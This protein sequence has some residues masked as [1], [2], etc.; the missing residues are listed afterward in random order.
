M[1]ALDFIDSVVPRGGTYC[2]AGIKD[3]IIDQRFATTLEGVQSNIDVL[4]KKGNNVYFA[5][6]SFKDD[7]SRKQKNV[8]EMKSFF[9]DVDIGD[10]EKVAKKVAYAEK[11]EA[12]AAVRGFIDMAGLPHP[13]IVDSGGGWHVYWVLDDAI[14]PEKWQPIADMFKQLCMQSG[15]NIDPAVPADSARILRVVGTNNTKRKASVKFLV[16]VPI[17]EPIA[18]TQFTSPLR[19]ACAKYGIVESMKKPKLNYLMDAATFNASGNKEAKFSTIAIRSL[20]GDGCAQIAD[21]LANPKGIHYDLWCAGLSIANKCIDGATA[22]HKLSRGH[23]GYTAEAT[24]LKAAEFNNGPRTCDWFN[25]NFP[26]NC[27]NCKFKGQFATPIKLGEYVPESTETEVV[28]PAQVM[29]DEVVGEI[30]ADPIV[31]KFPPLPFP[32]FRGTGGGIY[33]KGKAVDGEVVEDTLIYENDLFVMKRIRDT[34]DGEILLFN[35]ILPLDGLQEFAIPLKHISSFDRLRDGLA[36][37]G[38]SATKKRMDEI[39]TYIITANRELQ[40]H[41]RLEQSRPQFGWH[42]SNTVFV[43][44]NREISATGERYSPPSTG[45]AAL[46][47]Y[48]NPKGDYEKWKTLVKTLGRPGW[49]RHQLG[50]LVAFGAPLM[51]F[52]GEHGLLI[53]LVNKDSGTGKTLVQHFINSV[54]GDTSRLMMRKQDTLASRMHGIGVR[55]HLPTCMDEVTNLTMAEVSDLA[56]G[57]SEGRGKERMESGANK[58]RVNNTWWDT[59][60]VTSSNAS[61]ADKLTTNKAT[62][63]GELMR[64]FEID[65]IKP[66]ELDADF[67]QSLVAIMQN[68]YGHA[69]DLYIKTVMSDI[70]GMEALLSKVKRSMNKRLGTQSKERMWVAAFSAIITGGYIAKS[71]GIIDWDIDYLFKVLLEL[72]FGKRQEATEELLDFGSVL[73]EFLSENKGAILQINGAKDLRSGL[74]QAPIFNPNVRIVGRFEPDSKKLYLVRSVFKEHCVKRQIPFN[75]SMT[76]SMDGIKFKGSEKLRVM[77]GTGIDAPPVWLL[78]FEGDFG[79]DDVESAS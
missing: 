51:K 64:I 11:S 79:M 30:I 34:E 75:A 31:I 55:C 19:E 53:N 8:Q 45:T 35:L 17:P 66:E 52:T 32:Y 18:L 59:I 68:N 7:S 46:A 14:T 10:P 4:V 67:A 78:V 43:L 61:M 23:D 29:F 24:E 2:I 56:Y 36:H 70:A 72:A 69:G 38:V 60:G 22:I 39:M 6:S 77:R 48:L 12:L 40:K 28:I 33:R 44:G 1:K 5:L 62:A 3:D 13:A 27:T 54:Y 74:P 16:G 42:D 47:Q 57:F 25:T 15:L 49:E 41:M 65:I 50:A 63:D 37:H 21:M 26:T 73:G 9:L 20:K 76:S 71:V 58:A